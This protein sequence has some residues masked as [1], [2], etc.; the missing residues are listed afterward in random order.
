VLVLSALL[1]IQTFQNL[2]RVDTGLDQAHTTVVEFRDRASQDLPDDRKRAFQERL[3][4]EIRSVP[5]VAAAASSTH[6]PLSGSMWSHFFRVSGEAGA[7]QR[8]SRFAYVSPGYFET[9]GIPRRSGRTFDDRDNGRSSRVMVVNESFAR[10][11]LGGQ[12]PIGA[13]L[14][15][16][17]EP[18]FPETTY[19][20]IGVVGDT[21]YADLREE[22]CWCDTA[23]G[24]MPPIAYVP[25]G[26]IPSPYAWAPVVIRVSGPLGA[27]TPAIA[28]RVERLDPGIAIGFV[29]LKTLVRERLVRER[30]VAWLAGAFGFLAMTLVAV[31]LYGIV[32][33]LAAARRNEIGIRLSL[34]STRA[35]IAGLV[36]RDNLQLM[37]AGLALGIP[38][39]MAGMRS[40]GSLLFGLTATDVPTIVE[41]TSLLAIAG[42][43]AAAVPAWRAAQ[44]RPDAALRCD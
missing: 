8:A 31:G 28:R 21:R 32:A 11:H 44:T 5:G 36:L 30:M 39:A 20:V 10:G 1:F 2:A 19:E 9:L 12:D 42:V 18:G 43:L 40:A 24:S 17:A 3:T 6:V 41:A 23:N 26:Q 38:L 33:Y 16:I 22:D 7:K 4:E 13:T 27:V 14:R 15:T 29:E 35:Q 34:G 25:I 37:G